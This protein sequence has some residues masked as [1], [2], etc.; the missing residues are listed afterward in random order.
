MLGPHSAAYAF[1]PRIGCYL[2]CPIGSKKLSCSGTRPCTRC[3]AD[4]CE[5]ADDSLMD[6]SPLTRKR[7]TELEDKWVKRLVDIRERD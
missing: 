1:Q 3:Q 6:R 5:C 2:T 4:G 7:M